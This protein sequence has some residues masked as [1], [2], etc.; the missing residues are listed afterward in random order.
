[1]SHLSLNEWYRGVTISTL[2][3]GV[4]ALVLIAV[5]AGCAQKEKKKYVERPVEDLYNEAL[6]LME[7]RQYASAS[8]RFDEVER[9]HPY[10]GW[11]T[12]AQLLGGYSYYLANRYDEAILALDRFM[13]LHPAN[14]DVAYAMYLKGLSYY[15]QISDVARDQKIT[16]LALTAFKELI[17]RFP[18][19]KYA[20][21]AAIKTELTYDHLA[22]KEMEIGRY[23]HGQNQ[24]L[25][26]INRF[27]K[28]VDSYQTTT[29]VPEA[30]HRLT[31]AYLALGVNEEARRT[32]AVL[33]HNFPGSEWYI[34]SYEMLENK[35][36]R[37][38][39]PRAPWWKV[40]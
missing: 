10:S 24:Y 3:Y 31:E 2:W 38:E 39:E 18:K 15:E 4:L 28:V 9:Q 27:K 21:N 30:L 37:N 20:R 13:Q 29:H 25:A 26:A 23:Y 33:G 5:L 32:A 35:S 19:S 16:E 6:D 22:G 34:D 36:V 40:W 7:E 1:M 11:A 8:E 17:S 12:K 14:K